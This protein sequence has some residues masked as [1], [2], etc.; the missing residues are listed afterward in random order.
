MRKSTT[1][2]NFT[3]HPW[4]RGILFGIF[5]VYFTLLALFNDGVTQAVG[6]LGIVVL[7]VAVD[8]VLQHR[9]TRRAIELERLYTL[10]REASERNND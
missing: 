6:M 2:R 4:T 9:R 3:E 8:I 10:A 7:N 1:M 5:L